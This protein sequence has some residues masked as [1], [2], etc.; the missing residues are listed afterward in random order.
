MLVFELVF[1]INDHSVVGTAAPDVRGPA[2][3]AVLVL[4]AVIPGAL[5][6]VVRVVLDC[7]DAASLFVFENFVEDV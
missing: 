6:Q 5:E 4:G 3:T 2:P 1:A 7:L